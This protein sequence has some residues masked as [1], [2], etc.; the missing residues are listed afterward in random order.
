MS[1]KKRDEVESAQ[2]DKTLFDENVDAAA[3]VHGIRRTRSHREWAQSDRRAENPGIRKEENELR[4]QIR[5][6]E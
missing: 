3:I 6:R 5:L 1:S 2:K 4:L